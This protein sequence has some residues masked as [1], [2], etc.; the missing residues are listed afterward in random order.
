MLT[1]S[2]PYLAVN[3]KRDKFLEL[4]AKTL[5]SC[6]EATENLSICRNG[7]TY[8]LP[9]HS[10]CEMDL[11][12]QP[13]KIQHSCQTTSLTITNGLWFE[14]AEE[15]TWVFVLPKPIAGKITGPSE[16]IFRVLQKNNG[17]LKLDPGYSLEI[18]GVVLK[19]PLVS[20]LE[21]PET[22]YIQISNGSFHMENNTTEQITI[23]LPKVINSRLV[24]LR[25][26]AVFM[27]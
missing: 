11:F 7:V 15:D 18:D 27:H 10:S 9:G 21:G 2:K 13:D 3:R 23:H 8:Q 22:L 17:K 20:K 25:Q 16:G 19:A 4:S 24:D 5:S 1:T 12:T 14:M 26:E 6:K